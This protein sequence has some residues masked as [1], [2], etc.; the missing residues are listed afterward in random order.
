MRGSIYPINT[1]V[2]IKSTGVFAII[3]EQVFLLDGKSFLHYLGQIEGR[4]SGLY[5]ILHDDV[6]LECLPIGNSSKHIT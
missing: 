6:E 5:C 3:K 1:V 4:G 2:R